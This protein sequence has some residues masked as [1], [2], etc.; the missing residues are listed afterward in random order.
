MRSKIL[1]IGTQFNI[2]INPKSFYNKKTDSVGVTA[3]PIVI[4]LFG[5]V[6]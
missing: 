2:Y 5:G 3:R 1:K 6:P 4:E